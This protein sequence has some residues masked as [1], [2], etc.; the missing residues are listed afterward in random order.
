MGI[1]SLEQFAMIDQEKQLEKGAKLS[2][3]VKQRQP[4]EAI[5]GQLEF[6][7]ERNAKTRNALVIHSLHIQLFVMCVGVVTADETSFTTSGIITESPRLTVSI[8]TTSSH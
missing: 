2:K 6:E 4:K 3:L 7:R 1:Q 5:L 8:A